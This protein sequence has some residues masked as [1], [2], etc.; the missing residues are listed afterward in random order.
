MSA[1]TLQKPQDLQ[2]HDFSVVGKRVRK[3][4]SLEK[5]TGRAEFLLD[6]KLPGMLY[7]KIL[8]CR[9]PHAKILKIDSSKAESL[10]GVYAVI[11]AKDTPKIKFG[12]MKDN[13]PL[14]DEIVLSYRDEIAAVAAK[15]AETAEKALELI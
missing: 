1:T 13:L 6:L 8:R 4:D 3:Y 15:D 7:G 9:Y 2:V 12:F 11:T 14:K 10:E 5:V